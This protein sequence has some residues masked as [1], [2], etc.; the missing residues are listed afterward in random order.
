[1]QQSL[2]CSFASI[3]S[4]N[5]IFLNKYY[6]VNGV[7]FEFKVKRI[8]VKLKLLP[9]ELDPNVLVKQKCQVKVNIL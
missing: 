2:K 5:M 6:L 9:W 8:A 7:S 4:M 1:M 3:T